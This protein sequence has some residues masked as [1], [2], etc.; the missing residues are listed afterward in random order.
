MFVRE[1]NERFYTQFHQ[2]QK[3]QEFF[4]LRQFGKTITKYETELRKLVEFVP[5]LFNSEKYSCSKFEEG[6]TLKIQ[7]KIFVSGG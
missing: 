6:L 4:R 1:F 2:G 3:R 7:E 5:E